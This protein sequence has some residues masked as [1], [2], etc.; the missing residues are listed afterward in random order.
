MSS[1]IS[2]W[3]IEEVAQ[4]HLQKNPHHKEIM[5]I[6]EKRSLD[7]W[8]KLNCDGSCKGNGELAGCGGLL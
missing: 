1:K 2:L 6:A 7:G 5:Y 3:A 8:V 4:D